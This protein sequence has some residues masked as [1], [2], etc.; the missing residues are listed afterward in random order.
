MLGFLRTRILFMLPVIWGAS[1]LVFLILHLMPG[2][3]V[4][5]IMRTGSPTPEQLAQIRHQLGLDQP[6][7]IQYLTWMAHALRGDLGTS[8]FTDR[9]VAKEILSQLSSTIQLALAAV[10]VAV[11]MGG[12][13]GIVAAYRRNSWIDTFATAIAVIGVSMPNFWFGLLLIFVFAFQL[14]LFPAVGQSTP[15]ALVLPAFTLGFGF[16]AV[17]TR[18]LRSNLLEVLRQEYVLVARGKGLSE[19][20]VLSKHTIRNALIPIV[21]LLGMQLGGLLGGTVVVETVFARQGIGQLLVNAI[22]NK[23]IPVVQGTILVT[24]LG[25][26][27]TNFLV[28]V[29]YMFLDPRIRYV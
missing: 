9:P 20:V 5:L 11:V 25:F 22:L 3:P 12:A 10:T 26:I 29:V 1:T 24:A 6:L 21:T 19:Y 27:L 2:D 23:D 17:I 15:A 7:A 16:S 18:M 13:L 8:I 14:R 4:L 28:D